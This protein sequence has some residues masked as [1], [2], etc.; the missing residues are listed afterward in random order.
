MRPEEA[1]MEVESIKDISYLEKLINEGYAIQGPRHDPSKDLAV[2]RAFLRKGREFAPEGWLSRN[3]Y[4][5]VEPS[6]FTKGFRLAYKLIDG[7]PDER[8]RSNY[9]LS[10]GGEEIPLYLRMEVKT[11]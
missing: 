4:Q 11:D 3:G 6:T 1:R 8:F 7:F 9:G 5:F 2:F 10:R